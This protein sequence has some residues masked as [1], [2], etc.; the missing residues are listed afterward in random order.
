MVGRPGVMLEVREALAKVY[1][2]T[3]W[4]LTKLAQKNGKCTQK[5]KKR[6]KLIP[7]K[8]TH[9]QISYWSTKST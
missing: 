7:K 9:A 3:K 4:K 8:N 2:S 6:K 5:R 1:K